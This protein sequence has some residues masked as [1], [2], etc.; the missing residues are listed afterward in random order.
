MRIALLLLFV[1]AIGASLMIQSNAPTDAAAAANSATLA[2]LL[3]IIGWGSL[4]AFV[5]ML[6]TRR[7]SKTPPADSAAH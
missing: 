7:K 4:I 1:G 5:V 6:F 3:N 2:G